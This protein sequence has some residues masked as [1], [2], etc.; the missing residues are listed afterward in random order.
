MFYSL[1]NQVL[2]NIYK[3]VYK[4]LFPKEYKHNRRFWPLYRVQ[5]NV[6]GRLEKVFFKKRLV[7]NNLE[8]VPTTNKKCML[9]ATGP[10]IQQL[11]SKVFQN[12]EI[13]YIGVNGAI[14]LENIHYST[15]IIID[16][17]FVD[18]RFDLVE[19]VL[20]TNCTF[21][22][23]PRCLDMILRRVKFNNIHCNIKTIETITRGLMEV[24]LDK[25]IHV[26]KTA[27]YIYTHNNFG[28]SKDIF[29]GTFDYFT[30]AYVALQ[31]INALN[32]KEIYI[33]GLDMNNFNKPRFYETNDDKQ[34]TSLDIHTETVLHAFDIAALFFKKNQIE[35]FNLSMNSAVK[36]FNKV[37]ADQLSKHF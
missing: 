25:E 27:E 5:R 6:D 1:F 30:V 23:T 33:A 37:S 17:N 7:S 3:F 12:K 16:H 18:T 36:S 11:P 29:Y 19:K 4:I 22:T 9:I 21:Y 15:Y 35:V 34:P 32:Y 2:R 8:L 24:F 14:S 26:N 28:F 10:S 31:I 20:Q 13:D